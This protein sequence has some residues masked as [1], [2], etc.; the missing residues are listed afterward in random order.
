MRELLALVMI[1]AN[2]DIMLADTNEQSKV[3]MIVFFCEKSTETT[4]FR[5]EKFITILKSSTL[6]LMMS[7]LKG[8]CIY[9]NK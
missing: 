1:L 4:F 7:F 6:V 9:T 2:L 3:R 8:S 5:E